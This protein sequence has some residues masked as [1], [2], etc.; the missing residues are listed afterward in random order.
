MRIFCYILLMTLCANASASS[1]LLK[2]LLSDPNVSLRC[3]EMLED[4]N[5][6]IQLR[7]KI[8]ALIERN[9]SLFKNLKEQQKHMRLR[10]KANYRL[11]K[12][13][14]YIANLQV[15]S[16][17]EMIIRQGCPGLNLDN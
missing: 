15:Q 16:Q 4:R 12:N 5:G 3:K 17:E 9:I 10:L 2:E 1:D 8:S 11:L 6:K 14:L 13:E 7:Q